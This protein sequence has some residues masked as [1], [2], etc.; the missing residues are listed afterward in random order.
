MIAAHQQDTPEY[1]ALHAKMIVARQSQSYIDR[2][3][4]SIDELA[5]YVTKFN[6]PVKLGMENR[7][8]CH[9]CPIYSEFDMIADR[10]AGGPVGIWLDTGHAIMME[11]MGLQQLPLSKKVADMIV[12]MHIHDAV[13][14]LDH[15]APCTL[16]G[17][18]LNPYREY[19]VN[20][21]IKVLELSGRL[22]AEEIITGTDRFVEAYGA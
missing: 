8:M 4:K 20:S 14:A 11:E 22:T 10:F 7:A 21:P 17:D 2:M 5:E 13:D 15:Y 18:V 12:G 6:L 9:Q 3:M 16:L 19:I 1:K